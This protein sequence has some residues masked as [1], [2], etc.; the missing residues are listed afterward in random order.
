MVTLQMKHPMKRSPDAAG[1]LDPA[2][3]KRLLLD[4]VRIDDEIQCDTDMEMDDTAPATPVSGSDVV[5]YGAVSSG[6]L[7]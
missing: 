6:F 2:S 3:A 5:C 1:L 7:R 4:R